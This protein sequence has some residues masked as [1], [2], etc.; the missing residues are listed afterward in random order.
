[1]PTSISLPL[2]FGVL[3][4]PTLSLFFCPFQPVFLCALLSVS[5]TLFSC[6]L[7]LYF[8]G[9]HILPQTGISCVRSWSRSCLELLKLGKVGFD[10]GCSWLSL[11]MIFPCESLAPFHWAPF[12]KPNSL[13]PG[14]WLLSLCTWWEEPAIAGHL[15]TCLGPLQMGSDLFDLGD[16]STSL[17]S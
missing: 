11:T 17:T 6:V 9:P 10:L 13:P 16:V 5:V 1:M 12:A 2:L 4:P 3:F 8:S 15:S 7:F 14:L